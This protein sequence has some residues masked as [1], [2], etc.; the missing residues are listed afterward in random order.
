MAGALAAAPRFV[1][2]DESPRHG[3]EGDTR[4]STGR[5]PDYRTGALDVCSIKRGLGATT[6]LI[7]DVGQL[8]LMDELLDKTVGPVVFDVRI[9]SAI[10]LKSKDRV[11]SMS[12]ATTPT[13]VIPPPAQRAPLQL[14]N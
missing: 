12:P 9:D 10:S 4:P 1:F 11:A 6:F 7:D 3:R 8:E 5:H 13:L 2:N 14:V